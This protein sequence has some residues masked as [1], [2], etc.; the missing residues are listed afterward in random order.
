VVQKVFDQLHERVAGL[1]VHK[2]QVTAAV[3]VPDGEGGRLQDV[4]EFSTTVRGLLGLCDWL[5][6]HGVTHLAMEATGV[7]W[8]T[9]VRHEALFDRVG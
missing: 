1:D 8:K 2:A 4:A 5:A 6:A 7:Y 9:V 3:R